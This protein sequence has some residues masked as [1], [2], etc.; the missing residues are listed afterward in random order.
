VLFFQR[1]YG[2]DGNN[3][4]DPELLEAVN[5]G[6]EIQFTGK[7]AVPACVTRQKSDL[8]AFKRATDL[9]IGR[10]AERSSEADFF[11]FSQAWHGVQPA[12]ADDPDFRL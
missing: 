10:R 12:A 3:A 2:G 7:N 9:G 4:F 11:H 5:V 8:A 1:S 6:A